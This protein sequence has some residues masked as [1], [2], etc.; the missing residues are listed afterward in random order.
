MKKTK[1]FKSF[2]L[3]IVLSVGVVEIS[4]AHPWF[5]SESTSLG[6]QYAGDGVCMEAIEVKTY[7]FGFEVSS[8]IEQVPAQCD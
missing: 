1:L 2:A 8:H 3:A 7:F 6:K 5:G 4:E